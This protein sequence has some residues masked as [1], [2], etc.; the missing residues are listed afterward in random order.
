MQKNQNA[1]KFLEGV[2]IEYKGKRV[3][4][5]YF[6]HTDAGSAAQQ[7]IDSPIRNEAEHKSWLNMCRRLRKA[8]N[9]F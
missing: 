3:K 4:S 7:M 9:E 5:Q 6:D 2:A 8:I 1:V